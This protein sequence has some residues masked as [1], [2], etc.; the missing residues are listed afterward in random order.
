MGGGRVKIVIQFFD[1]FAMIA[2]MSS[3]PKEAFFQDRIDTVPKR[4][5]EAQTLVV[6]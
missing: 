5:R 4:K 6:V 2:L 1:I 3:E